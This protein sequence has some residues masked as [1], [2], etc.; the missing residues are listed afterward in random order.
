MVIAAVGKERL[1]AYIQQACV[2][3]IFPCSINDQK[4]DIS[5]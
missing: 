2:Q 4:L 1:M 5:T 3:N